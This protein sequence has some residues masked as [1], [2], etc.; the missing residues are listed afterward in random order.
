VIAAI[1]A[2]KSTDQN[3]ADEESP[4]RDRSLV[5]VSMPSARAGPSRTNTSIPTT[6]LDVVEAVVERAAQ[7]YAADPDV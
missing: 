4:S 5:L 3:I 2:R 6:T 7:L 1:Y